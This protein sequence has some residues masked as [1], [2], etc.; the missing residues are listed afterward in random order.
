MAAGP[1]LTRELAERRPLLKAIY[2]SW[3]TEEAIIQHGVLNS[4]MALLRKPF[5]SETLGRKIRE[6]LDR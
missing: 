5:T 1:E 2:M 6:V 3:Y 4:G